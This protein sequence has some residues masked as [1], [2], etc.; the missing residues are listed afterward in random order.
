[1]FQPLRLLDGIDIQPCANMPRN[2]AMERPDA[3]II[4]FVL[5]ND[6]AGVS[7]CAWADKLHVAAL[8]V[9]LVNDGAVPETVAFGKDVEVVAV[10]V[11][12]VG[13]ELEFVI[14]D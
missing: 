8:G 13:G 9:P 10:E 1:M 4:S 2:V 12:G 7:R 14:D 11:H 6:V 5:Q 3:G